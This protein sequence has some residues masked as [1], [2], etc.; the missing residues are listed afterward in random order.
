MIVFDHFRKRYDQ[1]DIVKIPHLE[2][3]PGVY[4]LRGE[5]GAGKSTLMRSVAGL[6]PFDGKVTVDGID[7][8][9]QRMLY[10]SMVN[11]ADAEPLYP[12][13]LTG[14]DLLSFVA[15]CKKAPAGQT[16][17]LCAALGVHTYCANGLKTYSSGMAKKLSL[18]LGLLGS[19]KLV[20]LDEPLIT[21][22]VEAVA[23]LQE[24]IAR[25]AANG[26]SFILSSHQ[27]L[28]VGE[29]EVKPLFLRNGTIEPA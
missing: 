7:I 20:L 28:Q 25:Y 21:L 18:V 5:N 24:I 26:V 29:L 16:D 12:G 27:Q 2:L 13:F 6:I 15:D 17:E 1:T 19:P 11:Y 8:R 10:T 14:N 23:T 9:Q 22:D 4:W 3:A